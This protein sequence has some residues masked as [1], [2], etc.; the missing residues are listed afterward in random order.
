MRGRPGEI[1]GVPRPAVRG[2]LT[3][4]R[5]ALFTVPSFK[6][7]ATQLGLNADTFNACVDSG[8]YNQRV[9]DEMTEAQQKGVS[10]TPTFFISDKAIV[11]AQSYETF[12]AAIEE[13]VKK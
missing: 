1:L 4:D 10:G 5:S 13:Q 3:R 6:Q 12:K 2:E 11:G 7:L 9:N 8:K